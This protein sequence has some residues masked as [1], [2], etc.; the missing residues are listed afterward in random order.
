LDTTIFKGPRFAREG[1][2]DIRMFTKPTSQALH[3][4]YSSHHP[5]HTFK[6]ILNGEYRRSLVV[7]SDRPT[8]CVE[9]VSKAK[10]FACRGYPMKLIAE[11]LLQEGTRCQAAFARQKEEVMRKP[12]PEAPSSVI[13]LKLEYTPRSETL[14]RQLNMTA[15]QNGISQ[16]CPGLSAESL[17]RLVIANTATSNLREAIRPRG[18]TKT[19][20]KS[21]KL[22]RQ[23]R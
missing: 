3:L 18:Y 1:K 7:S 9:M 21:S 13:A 8:H 16:A 11:T 19:K 10:Q 12:G 22:N 5:P 15:L 20:K 14:R 23:T 4:P 2:L 6:G 17:G